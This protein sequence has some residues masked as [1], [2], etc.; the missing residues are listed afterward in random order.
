ANPNMIF[1]RITSK[2]QAIHLKFI[3]K[4]H[5][6]ENNDITLFIMDLSAKRIFAWGVMQLPQRAR[7]C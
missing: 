2:S 5:I 1:I 3:N 7:I 4:N 6:F